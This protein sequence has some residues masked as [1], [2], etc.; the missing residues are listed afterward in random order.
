[1]SSECIASRSSHAP[2]RILMI[3]LSAH[4]PIPVKTP[5]GV[6]PVSISTAVCRARSS[7]RE[8]ARM[9]ITV[10]MHM[11]CSRVGF[12]LLSIEPGCARMR[13]VVRGRSAS[14]PTRRR[15]SARC[16]LPPVLLFLLPPFLAAQL[17][18]VLIWGVIGQL[19]VF[20]AAPMSP[21]LSPSSPKWQSRVSNS[22]P[23][24]LQLAGS[25]LRSSL[26]ARDLDLEMM[27]LLTLENKINQQHQ[28]QQ[29]QQKLQM[30]DEVY[31]RIGELKRSGIDNAFGSL[32]SSILASLNGS[33]Q[34][35]QL[36][37]PSG[38]QLHQNLNHLRASYPLSSSGRKLSPNRLDSS[39]PKS[40]AAAMLNPRAAA[41]AKRSVSFVDRGAAASISSYSC[42]L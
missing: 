12:T 26:S 36:E 5:G 4:L 11:G 15:S 42:W 22:P 21:T 9:V 40:V 31:G 6:I 29:Q 24:S 39:P 28:Q 25:R 35:P 3:G 19:G 32:S 17:V 10:S 14:L 23:P 27:E 8:I 37:S 13:P 20:S 38:L 18:T 16:T 1:M 34:L 2:E 30:M 41:F 7:R 33:Q